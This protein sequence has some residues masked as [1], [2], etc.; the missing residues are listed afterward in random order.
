MLQ[1]VAAVHIPVTA[2]G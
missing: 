2:L 1:T